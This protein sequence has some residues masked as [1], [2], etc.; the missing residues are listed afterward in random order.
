MKKPKFSSIYKN[1]MKT[2]YFYLIGS[3]RR[4]T[5]AFYEINELV[6]VY[7]AAKHPPTRPFRSSLRASND[8]SGE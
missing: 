2:M 4:V 5:M 3:I 6:G 8:V 7:S 1:K